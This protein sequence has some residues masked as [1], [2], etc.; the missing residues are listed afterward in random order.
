MKIALID[1]L[2]GKD[3]AL[4]RAAARGVPD[5]ARELI[6]RGANVNARSNRGITPLHRAA[7]NG[8]VEIV[9]ML[10]DGGAE[11]DIEANDGETPLSMAESSGH[12]AVVSLL[13]ARA[14]GK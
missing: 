12:D 1:W 4:F 13:R 5:M 11:P 8:H 9:E 3:G 14:A 10:L 7:Q 2:F 6:D